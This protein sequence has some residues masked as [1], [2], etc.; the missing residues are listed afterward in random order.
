MW[1]TTG[2]C[3][4]TLL[5]AFVTDTDK[6][7]RFVSNTTA[8]K[9]GE[10]LNPS[11]VVNQDTAFVVLNTTQQLNNKIQPG[12]VAK[13]NTDTEAVQEYLA[14]VAQNNGT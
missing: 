2:C 5:A 10:M 6:R 7:E 3:P 14:L 13:S 9:D 8:N 12:T 4:A 11:T 1:S